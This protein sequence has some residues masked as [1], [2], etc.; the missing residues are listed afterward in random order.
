MNNFVKKRYFVLIFVLITFIVYFFTQYDLNNKTEQYLND[1]TKQIY[2]E[3]KVIYNNY[4]T[5]ADLI[6]K[7]DINTQ[8]IVDL[9]KNRKRDQLYHYLNTKYTKLREYN[10]RQLHFHTKS[11]D[12]FLRMHRP[13][14]FGDNLTDARATV[15]YVNEYKKQID[16]FEEGKVFNGFRFVYPMFDKK[17]HIGSVEIS[18]SSLFFIKSMVQNY[19]VT[20]NLLIDKNVV[21][22]KVFD[23]EKS[24]YIDSPIDGYYFQRSVVEYLKQN[25]DKLKPSQTFKN[26]VIEKI[27]ESKPFSLYSDRSSEIITFIPL[28]NPITN[29]VV[30][31]LVVRSDDPFIQNKTDNSN[32]LFFILT[33]TS[34]I[35]LILIY[36]QLRYQF[37]LQKE[38]DNKTKELKKLNRSLEFKVKQEI[39]KNIQ[40]DKLVQEQAKLASMGEMIG[41]IA[42]QWRQPL[43]A[44]NINIQNLDDDFEDGLIDKKFIDNFIIKNRKIIEFMSQT[45]DDFRNFFRIDKEKQNFWIKES[46][47]SV[48]NIQSAQ[49]ANHNINIE[50]FGDDFMIN[51]LKSE[52]Q[53]VILNIINNAKDEFMSK[54]LDNRKIIIRL[55]DNMVQIQDN[56]GGIAKDVINRV[57]EPYYT[58]KQQGKGTGMGLYISKL[59]IEHSMD[60]ILMVHNSLDGATFTISFKD[61]KDA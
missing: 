38:I 40:K 36:N 22:G 25:I 16:G 3:Y 7:T 61:N 28:K 27:K 33:I 41:S 39:E 45:I 8:E 29:I 26:S 12:S 35:I 11:N 47:Q 30:A 56:A 10:V 32:I 17:E 43:N 48:I 53:Q 5:L 1:K 34:G 6:Y 20:S 59:I 19:K 2:L 46:I 24:N 55:K 23:H 18:F 57:F 49:L 31:S 42:H 50:F 15:R 51:G 52:F 58:T 60:G 14:R 21:D 4:K 44:L 54:N 37:H 9:F 13:N